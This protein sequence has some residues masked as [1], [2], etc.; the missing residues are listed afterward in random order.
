MKTKKEQAADRFLG[1]LC[2][3]YAFA[4]YTF[5]VVLK[6]TRLTYTEIKK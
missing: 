6:C 3:A 2:L 1:G 5:F 4:P